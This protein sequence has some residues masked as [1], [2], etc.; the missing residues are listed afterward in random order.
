MRPRGSTTVEIAFM[1]MYLYRNLVL[2]GTL[3]NNYNSWETTRRKNAEL[4]KALREKF[5]PS[6]VDEVDLLDLG[7]NQ[8]D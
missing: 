7:S 8:L 6:Y 5:C 1:E 3:D 4:Y 2:L